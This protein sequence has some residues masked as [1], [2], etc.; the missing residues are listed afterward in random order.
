[1]AFIKQPIKPHI[2]KIVD[3]LDEQIVVQKQILEHL[4]KSRQMWLEQQPEE[5]QFFKLGEPLTREYV[6][7]FLKGYRQPVQTTQV[8]DILYPNDD[9]EQRYNHIK[10]LSVMFNQMKDKGEVIVEKR[11]GVKGN[12]YSWSSQVS[13][14]DRA[15]N[16][17]YSMS[18]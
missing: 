7:N 5:V 3:K 18:A 6:R 17:Q 12:F 2:Q 1:M 15:G 11:E 9:V 13:P 8:I 16:T 14:S 10:H 4:E